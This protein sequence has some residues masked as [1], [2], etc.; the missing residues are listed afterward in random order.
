MLAGVETWV[1]V[2]AVADVPVE[3]GVCALV[4]GEPVAVVLTHD[5]EVHA[6]G[7]VDPASGASVMSRG[8]VGTRGDRATLAS[9][10][11]KHVYDLRT[12]ICVDD[13]GLRL[14][15]FR[16]RVR[17]RRVEVAAL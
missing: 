15:V 8:I 12:G 11:Y 1:D 16:C 3:Q 14:A 7:D 4:G 5:G 13:P 9:P 6:V 2:C 17:N 10:M